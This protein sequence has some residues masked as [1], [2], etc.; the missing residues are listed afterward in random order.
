M[1]ETVSDY[2]KECLNC[3][4]AKSPVPLKQG[5]AKSTIHDHDGSTLGMDLIG[6][7]HDDDA[8]SSYILTM[9]D[10]FSHFLVADVIDT[11]EA[12]S[13]FNSFVRNILLEGRLPS[14]IVADNG[15]EFKNRIFHEFLN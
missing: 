6:P 7:L 2:V 8:T 15:T 10:G 9:Y 1:A 13:V 5:L 3:R 11:K 12:T 4:K 14:R